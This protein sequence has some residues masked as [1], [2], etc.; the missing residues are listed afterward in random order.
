MS[1]DLGW[2]LIIVLVAF[3]FLYRIERPKGNLPPP[4]SDDR[5]SLR[6]W[7]NSWRA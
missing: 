1:P 7:R 2:P 4:V 5:D 3:W 6:F